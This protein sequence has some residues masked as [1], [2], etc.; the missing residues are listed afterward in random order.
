MLWLYLR[1]PGIALLSERSYQLIAHHRG[2]FS[3]LTRFFLGKQAQVP[4]YFLSRWLFLRML[5]AIFFIAF[6]SLWVQ[7]DGLVG[8]TGILLAYFFLK[9]PVARL[10]C[11]ALRILP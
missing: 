8:R 6:V 5:G 7:I 1:I 10:G 9:V 3:K 11:Q 2:G 4:T